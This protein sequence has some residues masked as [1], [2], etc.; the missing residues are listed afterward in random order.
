MALDNIQRQKMIRKLFHTLRGQIGVFEEAAARSNIEAK[1]VHFLE[2]T[3][4]AFQEQL[5]DVV[6]TFNKQDYFSH[7]AGSREDYYVVSGIRAYMSAALA[8]LE[9]EIEEQKSTPVTE[10]RDFTFISE[11]EIRRIVERD[12]L[13]IQKAFVAGCWKAVIILAGGTIEA[14]LLDVVKM[15]PSATANPKAPKGKAPEAWDLSSLI[16]VSLEVSRITP[17][18]EK[19]SHSIRDYR[20]LVHPGKELRGRLT[21]SREEAAIALEVLHLVHRDLSMK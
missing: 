20:N 21:P 4:S 7:K 13:E 6:P 15:T 1:P 3:L 2:K 18:L 9:V 16:D 17:G 10:Q 12:Y 14:I 5:P 8:A 19:L 11:P